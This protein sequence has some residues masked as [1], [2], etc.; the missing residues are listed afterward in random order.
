MVVYIAGGLTS[1]ALSH[2][3]VP[4]QATV[5]HSG[6][7]NSWQPTACFIHSSSYHT[8]THMRQVTG[9]GMCVDFVKKNNNFDLH[10]ARGI[11][12]SM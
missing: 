11:A 12:S 6:T 10:I 8:G 2:H 7:L 1:V 4:N 3:T 5:L 9:M